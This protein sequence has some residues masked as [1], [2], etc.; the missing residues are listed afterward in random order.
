MTQFHTHPPITTQTRT[1]TSQIQL[2]SAQSLSPHQDTHTHTLVHTHTHTHRSYR[3]RG[4][5]RP[6]GSCLQNRYSPLWSTNQ[7]ESIYPVKGKT[8]ARVISAVMRQG[9]IIRGLV[10]ETP[11]EG[12]I[13]LQGIL[14]SLIGH[15]GTCTCALNAVPF[16][17]TAQLSRA[18]AQH[19]EDVH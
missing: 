9:L 15:R 1:H 7:N 8:K 18:T 13:R 17:L 4:Q 2:F 14:C 16:P 5:G 6:I 12:G 3:H 11:R 10:T 19:N